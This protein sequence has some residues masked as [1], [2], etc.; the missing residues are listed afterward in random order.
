MLTTEQ[1]TLELHVITYNKIKN[2][3]IY[4]I[5]NYIL[6]QWSNNEDVLIL[7]FRNKYF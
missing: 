3:N 7:S 4:I 2:K 1:L 6:Q 5:M